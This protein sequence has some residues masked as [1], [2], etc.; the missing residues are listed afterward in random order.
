MGNRTKMP[1]ICPGT[2]LEYSALSLSLEASQELGKCA[3]I[4]QVGKP[5][6]GEV[7]WLILG[8]RVT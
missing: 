7:E 8:L 2:E 6:H 1:L 5:R 4:S 3:S